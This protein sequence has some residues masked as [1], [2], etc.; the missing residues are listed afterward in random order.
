MPRALNAPANRI[1]VY[2]RRRCAARVAGDK[3]LDETVDNRLG[4]IGTESA[5]GV[6]S[7]IFVGIVDERED[8][9]V[10]FEPGFAERPDS[11]LP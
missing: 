7:E 1:M 8:I 6:Q 11:G 3:V 5:D 10:A 9:F 4:S 2:G